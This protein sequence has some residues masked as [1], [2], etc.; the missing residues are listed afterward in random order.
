[1]VRFD[2]RLRQLEAQLTDRSGLV[3]H[4]QQWFDYWITRV[5]KLLAGEKLDEKIPLAFFDVLIAG[6]VE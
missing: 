4:T 5:D 2:R 6:D 1:M 3:P